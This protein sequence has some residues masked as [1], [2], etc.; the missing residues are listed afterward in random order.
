MKKEL[1]KAIVNFILDN[2]REFQITNVTVQNFRLY[3]YDDKGEYLIG[4]EDVS[5]FI[6]DAIDLLIKN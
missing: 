2:E 3:I 5:K 1:K 6:H 4:G